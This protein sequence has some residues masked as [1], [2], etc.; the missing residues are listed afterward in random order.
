[1]TWRT[2]EPERVDVFFN[3]KLSPGGY[4]YLFILDGIATFGCAIV[5]DFKGIDEYF[6]H[7]S[8]PRSA[9]IHSRS[10]R[11]RGPVTRT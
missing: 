5:A 6:E 9:G 1:M 4:S 3:H 10:H 11:R 2:T 7:S 8:P